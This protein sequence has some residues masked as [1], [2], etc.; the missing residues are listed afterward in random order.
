MQELYD[1]NNEPSVRNGLLYCS[2]QLVL[3]ESL[4]PNILQL[5]HEGHFGMTLVKRGLCQHYWLPRLSKQL[6][7]LVR[8]SQVCASSENRTGRTKHHLPGLLNQKDSGIKL[9]WT[10]LVPSRP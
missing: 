1:V 9:R 4:R 8:D 2:D 7:H 5:A 3:P 10:S 6:E